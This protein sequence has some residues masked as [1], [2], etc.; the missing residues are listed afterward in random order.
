MLIRPR[1]P[2]AALDILRAAPQGGFIRALNLVKHTWIIILLN[3]F[4]SWTSLRVVSMVHK[5]LIVGHSFV[6]RLRRYCRHPIRR[7]LRLSRATHRIRMIGEYQ[8]RKIQFIR[9]IARAANAMMAR[10]PRPSVVILDIGSN[11]LM[12]VN[13]SPEGLAVDLVQLAV[14]L[15]N[16]GAKRVVMT[17]IIPRL[18]GAA[19]DQFSPVAQYLPI[20]FSEQRFFLLMNRFNRT[21]DDFVGVDGRLE[22][23]T[24]RGFRGRLWD[25]L[26][27]GLHYNIRGMRR[28]FNSMRRQVVLQCNKAQG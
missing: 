28:Y 17:K 5:V 27:D 23:I 2:R 15:L 6:R 25:V 9:D 8:G 4:L 22:V 10:Y 20:S 1:P 3:H 7:H 13:R 12:S 14:R 21:L 16:L 24:H 26:A 18:G 11:D 19:V